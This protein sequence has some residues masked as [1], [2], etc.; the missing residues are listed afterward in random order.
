MQSDWMQRSGS[1]LMIDTEALPERPWATCS[2][3]NATSKAIRKATP[4]HSAHLAPSDIGIKLLHE[5]SDSHRNY[6]IPQL[7]LMDFPHFEM[8]AVSKSPEVTISGVLIQ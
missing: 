4:N 3:M 6:P 7:L 2:E 1:M 5:D 8:I